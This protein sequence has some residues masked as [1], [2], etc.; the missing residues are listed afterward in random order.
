MATLPLFD[1]PLPISENAGIIARERQK[2]MM[3]RAWIATGLFFMALPGTLLGFSNLMAISAHRGLGTLPAAWMEGHGHAQMF[4]W[5]GSFILGIGFYS[6]PAHGRSVLRVSLSCFVLWTSGVGLR[7]FANIYGWHWRTLLPLSAGFELVAVLLFLLAASHHKLPASA[8]GSKRKA[9][10]ELWMVSVLIGT[11]GLTSAVIF[12]FVECVCLG[13]QGGLRS[14]P[15]SL[16]QKYLVLLGWGFVV[17]VV[18]GFSARWLPTFLATSKPNVHWFRAAL[19]LVVSGV[20]L[21][22][23]G[24]PKPATI[25][26]ATSAVAIGLALRFAERPRGRAKTQGIH[27]SFPVFARLP[28]AWLIVAALMSVWAAFADV[29]GGIWG[30]S[31]HALTVGFAATMVFAIGPRIL[32]HFAGIQN[33]FSKHLMFFSLLFLQTGC[34]LRVSSEPLAYEGLVSSAWKVLPVSGMLELSG[35]LLFATN[36]ALTFLIGRSAFSVSTTSQ[37]SAA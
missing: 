27:P 32:P 26:F 6:Q 8:Q 13:L 19:C 36:L 2:S 15:H 30:A 28:Y 25:L 12:N 17:P 11:A 23:A 10:I 4:G 22:V 5:I 21:G 1:Q 35:V 31:R 16:D 33:I 18:W 9:P 24:W 20:L 7:W 3:L 34:L 37:R 14:F 29:H